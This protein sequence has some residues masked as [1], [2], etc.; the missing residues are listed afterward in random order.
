MSFSFAGVFADAAALWRGE[1]DLLL[2]VAG[3]FFLLPILGVVLLLSMLELPDDATAD[4]LRAAVAAFYQA[5]LG[6]VLLANLTINF[7]SFAVLNLF[8]QGGGRTLGEVLK[9]TLRRFLPF[10]AIDVVAGLLFALG[11]SLFLL[12]GL[13]ALSRTWLAAPAFAADPGKGVIDAFRQGWR[14]SGGFGWIVIAGAASLTLVAALLAILIAGTVLG[15]VSGLV[16][17]GEPIMIVANLVTAS[18]GAL[19]WTALAVMR[20]SFYRLSEPKQGI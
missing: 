3:V 15:V 5:N 18:I 2:R 7:G 6:A 17:G 1:R 9:S 11:A 16:G 13:F 20:V 19:A 8:L 4:Q 14:R 12:P 10:L